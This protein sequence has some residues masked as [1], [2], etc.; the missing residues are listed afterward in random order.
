MVID[1]L[2]IY[3]TRNF[4][5]LEGPTL[6]T[7]VP[8]LNEEKRLEGWPTIWTFVPAQRGVAR[9]SAPGHR[10]TLVRFGGSYTIISAFKVFRFVT[11]NKRGKKNPQARYRPRVFHW[12]HSKANTKI[13]SGEIQTQKYSTKKDNSAAL[14]GDS[15]A[16]YI[17]NNEMLKPQQKGKNTANTDTCL[18]HNK[19]WKH[20]SSLW[21]KRALGMGVVYRSEGPKRHPPQGVP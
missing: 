3:W 19:N 15:G 14:G 12:T 18:R 8:S 6:R 16:F 4:V 10:R 20:R 1:H 21:P 9:S 5:P 2:A 17:K 11:S 7:P 13:N